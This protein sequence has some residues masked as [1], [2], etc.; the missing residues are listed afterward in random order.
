M[1]RYISAFCKWLGRL[2]EDLYGVLW[3]QWRVLTGYFRRRTVSYVTGGIVDLLNN[4][5]KT[6]NMFV[7][8]FVNRHLKKRFALRN[9]R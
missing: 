3:E 5:L 2:E 7:S 1:F 6:H 8:V 9:I 4:S